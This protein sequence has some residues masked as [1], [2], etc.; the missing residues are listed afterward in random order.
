[1]LELTADSPAAE[2]LRFDVTLARG[3]GY[4]TGCIFEI[5]VAD[6]AGSLG[7]GGR[8]DGLIGMFS[9]KDVPACGITLGLE[10]ILVVMAERGMYPQSLLPVDVLV[11]AASEEQ[12]GKALSVARALR[13]A[14][15]RVDLRPKALKKIGKLRAEAEQ[16][17]LP[18]VVWLERD[19][20]EGANVWVRGPEGDESGGETARDLPTS[21]IAQRIRA[22]LAP[23]AGE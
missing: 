9:G 10:R 20:S 11:G 18:A 16:A 5:Q 22:R 7:G 23:G 3:L 2:H 1:V 19:Q 6:L 13:D 21:E 14:G 8:Y 17:G 4:Y 12:L 15:L